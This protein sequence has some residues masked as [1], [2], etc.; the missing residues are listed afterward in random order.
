[1]SILTRTL[2]ILAL[3][4]GTT[5]A[6]YAAPASVPAA[7]PA[8]VASQPAP[9]KRIRKSDAEWKR[10]LTPEQY[11][12]LRE[13]GT[14]TAFTGKYWNEHRRGVYVCAG[15]GLEL[16]RSD[17]KFDSKTGWPSFTRAIVANHVMNREDT[18]LGETRTA[19]Q[20]AR[21]GGHLGHLFD[22]GPPP[23]GLR[24]CINS[25]ALTFVPGK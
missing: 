14:E 15:C 25:A 10:L 19:L 22:D 7:R 9:V 16:F 11:H 24:F 6:A 20:C 2:P 5:F 4:A 12:V 3:A 17:D 1:M 18:S 23:T 8:A 21:C 13:A